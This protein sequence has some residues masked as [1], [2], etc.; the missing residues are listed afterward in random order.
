MTEQYDN[1][2]SRRRKMILVPLLTL[3]L[4]IFAITAIAYSALIGAVSNE[5]NVIFPEE[6]DAKFLDEDG[7]LMEKGEFARSANEGTGA[8]KISIESHRVNAN[9]PTF[10][11]VPQS[12]E[13]G[14]AVLDI[15]PN[16]ESDIRFVTIRYELEWFVA[17]PESLY[18]MTT[19]LSVDDGG[20]ETLSIAEGEKSESL[21]ILREQ[22]IVITLNGIIPEELS[23]LTEVSKEY[24]YSITI[25]VEPYIP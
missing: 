21:D 14:K 13:L 16:G 24:V 4:C 3:L 11:I 25:Y 5:E 9:D 6:L 12:L 15:R 2:E 20:D 10:T 18:G 23:G 22:D 17:D 8:S 7:K 1:D 19:Y